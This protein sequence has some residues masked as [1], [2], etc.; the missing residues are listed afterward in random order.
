MTTANGPTVTTSVTTPA[1]CGQNNGEITTTVT[2]GTAPYT[3]LWS[4]GAT[5]QN[6][7]AVGVGNYTLTVTD[8]NGCPATN[9]TGIVMTSLNAPIVNIT[10]VNST[11][12]NAN[13]SA[14]ANA[15][16]GV[17]NYTYLWIPG[18]Q[19]TAS[20]SSLLPGNYSV[21]VTD[22]LGCSTIQD[23]TINATGGISIQSSSVNAICGSSLGS[24]SA[25]ASGGDGN[26]TYTWQPGNLNGATQTNVPAGTYTLTV[27]DGSGCSATSAENV[28]MSGSLN[29][30]TNPTIT[31]IDA[32]ESVNLFA[33]YSPQIPGAIYTW[34]PP[35]GLSC[36]DCPNPIATPTVT[37]NYEVTVTTPDGCMGKA[38]SEVRI[39]IVCGDF[40]VPTIFS[41]NGDGQNDYFQIYGN[42]IAAMHLKVFDRWGELVFES[43]DQNFSWDG[44]FKG[45]IMNS[46]SFV[47][48]LSITTLD[49]EIKTM[50]GNVSLTR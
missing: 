38:N 1:S 33:S 31:V 36:T 29:V 17:G 40:F 16:G 28:T 4:N 8:A 11:C 2:G 10:S 39:R 25:T 24:L 22:N 6:L 19:T 32:G 18:G 47:Y 49:G 43:D 35:T 15:S 45:E 46:A 12:N 41:P 3:Y 44:T 37:T 23:V 42:C 30:Q 21:T 7:S 26:Y 20:I 48:H 9:G 5:T 34:T 50:K 14:T 13:G 27:T